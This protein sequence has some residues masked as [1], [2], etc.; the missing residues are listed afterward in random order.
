MS[1]NQVITR[2]QSTISDIETLQYNNYVETRSMTRMKAQ[3]EEYQEKIDR[4]EN[5]VSELRPLCIKVR[6]LRN[7]NISLRR[8]INSATRSSQM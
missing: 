1:Y 3:L 7:Q 2:L 8:A 5:E 4:L 6:D